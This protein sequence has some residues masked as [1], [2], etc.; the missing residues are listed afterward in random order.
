[1]KLVNQ[2][3]DTIVKKNI[4]SIS[5]T[6]NNSWFFYLVKAK[7]NITTK[8]RWL[9]MSNRRKELKFENVGDCKICISH[10]PNQYGVIRTSKDGRTVRLHRWYWEN[11]HGEI[12]KGMFIHHKCGDARCMN[13]DHM[14]MITMAEKNNRMTPNK[15]E[16]R[17]IAKLTED[18][19]RYIVK[20]T[21]HSDSE[22]AEIMGV[23]RQHINAIRKGHRGLWNHLWENGVD[24]DEVGCEREVS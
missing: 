7:L 1:M 18:D 9:K 19:V 20:D 12:P 23:T 22:M 5:T 17:P 14:E 21:L 8:W 6:N 24:V 2:T 3:L 11:E 13:V 16:D 15:G 10:V 4:G